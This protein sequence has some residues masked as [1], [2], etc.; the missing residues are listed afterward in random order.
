MT[1]YVPSHTLLFP[2]ASPRPL[3]QLLWSSYFR[4][5]MDWKQHPVI[6]CLGNLNKEPLQKYDMEMGAV[7]KTY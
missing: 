3:P 7:C 1:P 6:F 2:A 4:Q 5:V